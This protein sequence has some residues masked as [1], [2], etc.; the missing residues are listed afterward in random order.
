MK[1]FKSLIEFQKH[2]GTDEQCRLYLEEQRWSGTPACP[3]CGSLNVCRFKTD[4]RILKCR[5]KQCR[6]KFSVTVGT[7]YQDRKLPLH[8]IFLAV[9]ILSVHSKGISSLQLANILDISQKAA[10]L[11]NHKVRKMLTEKDPKA[12]DGMVQVDETYVGQRFKNKHAKVRKAMR[13]TSSSHDYKTPV[14]GLL[15]AGKV[16]T[17]VVPKATRE[18]VLPLLI[19]NI[20]PQSVLHT[21]SSH[22]YTP[23]KKVFQHFSVNHT[24]NEYVRWEGAVAIHTNGIENF[25]SLLKR[26]INGIHHFVSPKHLQRYCNEAAFRFNNKTLA[27]DERFANALQNCEG[28]LQWKELVK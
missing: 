28:T 4:V 15:S 7:V 6:K 26:Q 11:L 27:Q 5:E 3:H 19:E 16:L 8:K 22:I 18:H 24:R 12:L 2:F 14:M 21:D 25:W 20:V 9:Y 10:W 1:P 23:L 13:E 17:F